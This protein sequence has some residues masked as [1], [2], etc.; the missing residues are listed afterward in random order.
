MTQT[1]EPHPCLAQPCPFCGV[2]AHTPCVTRN[3][4]REQRYPHSRRIALTRPVEERM[5][6]RADALCCV[7]GTKRTVNADYRR[8]QDPN[9]SPGYI[10]D[11]HPQG[12]R[13]TQTLR[14]I[15]CGHSTRHAMLNPGDSRWR[16]GDERLQRVALG[17]SPTD[18]E[19]SADFVQRLRK[20][21]RELFP[22]NPKLYH[23]FSTSAAEAAQERGDTHMP[24]LCGDTAT[25]PPSWSKSTP[26]SG[27]VAPERVDWDTEFEDPE[28]GEWWVD[29]DC[30]N[31]LRVTNQRRAAQR[32]R[33]LERLLA[34]FAARPENIP[35]VEVDEVV[36]VLE[37]FLETD[38]TD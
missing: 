24:A 30:V 19:Y 2:D 10:G 11:G 5:P 8:L 37:Q 29:M 35:D 36:A 15:E 22:H 26:K 7:C 32:R 27:P 9:Y 21:Y 1:T 28:T 14:C 18:I 12:W 4:G 31:C 25:V 23:W 17:E 6:A 33:Q 34:W 3:S 20:E 13:A 38:G 16:Y